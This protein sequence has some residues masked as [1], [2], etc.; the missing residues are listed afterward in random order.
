M[1]R[2]WVKPSFEELSVGAECTAYAGAVVLA[3]KGSDS[4]CTRAAAGRDV[5]PAEVRPLTAAGKG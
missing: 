2:K 1:D 4:G 5:E 3:T